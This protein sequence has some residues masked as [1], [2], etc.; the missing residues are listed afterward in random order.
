MIRRP[1]RSTLFPYTTLFRSA[2]LLPRMRTLKPGAAGAAA[3]DET[4]HSR[5]RRAQRG[6]AT[7]KAIIARVNDLEHEL[8]KVVAGDVRFDPISRLLYSTDA[9]MYQVEPIGVVIPR[10][11][12][13]VQAAVEVARKHQVALLPR[14]GG[15]SLTGQTVNRALVLDFAR[16]MNRVLE[17]NSEERWARVEPG[18]VQDEL[19]HHVR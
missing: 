13:D 19:N 1:P 10:D 15:T 14:G 11:A 12:D 16:H 18:L 9:S 5:S 6:R 8:R 2:R 17:V 7:T 3:S 4:K